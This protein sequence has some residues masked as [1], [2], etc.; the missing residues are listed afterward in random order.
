MS[1]CAR[2]VKEL[3]AEFNERLL[4]ERFREDVGDVGLRGDVLDADDGVE[5]EFADLEVTT[6][7]VLFVR[8]FAR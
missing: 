7:D 8:S 1:R 2:E 6:L 4:V 3:R 5:H